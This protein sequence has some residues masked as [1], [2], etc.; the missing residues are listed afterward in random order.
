MAGVELRGLQQE[1]RPCAQSSFL[2]S[3]LLAV[4][5]LADSVRHLSGPE[6]LWGKW[7]PSAEK[8]GDNNSTIAVSSQGYTTSGE[9]CAVQW[10]TETAGREGPI[11]SAHM[12]CSASDAPEQ[13]TELNRIIMPKGDGQVAAGPDFSDL[14]DFQRC[15]A[16]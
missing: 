12:R 4:A 8:C 9:S 1:R 2:A 5:A 10:V 11:Y 7:A 14:K 15:P 16:N 13:K 3:A 6:R